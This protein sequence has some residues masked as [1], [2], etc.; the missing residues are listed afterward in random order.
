MVHG[1]L[2]SISSKQVKIDDRRVLRSIPKKANGQRDWS[3][4][5]D[6]SYFI[7]WREKGKRRRLPAGATVAQAL[8]VQRRKHADLEALA[9]GIIMPR[10][11]AEDVPKP[12][13][14]DGLIDRCLDQ[15]ETLKK[16][17]TFRKYNLAYAQDLGG[18]EGLIRGNR[19]GTPRIP[20]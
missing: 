1:W 14:L 6:G 8:E 20:R 2:T 18:R 9:F 3:S 17:N 5:P 11:R 4:L 10:P 12:V 15:I 16:P 19:L 13:L 7:E